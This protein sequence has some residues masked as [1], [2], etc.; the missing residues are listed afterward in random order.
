MLTLQEVLDRIR[1]HS[2]KLCEVMAVAKAYGL[3]PLDHWCEATWRVLEIA[4]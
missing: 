1:Q 3:P 4:L 2:L